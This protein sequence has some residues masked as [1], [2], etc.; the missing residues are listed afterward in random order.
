MDNKDFS[1][2]QPNI[3]MQD[4]LIIG[5]SSLYFMIA[6]LYF[7]KTLEI[8]ALIAEE[9]E[10]NQNLENQLIEC[11]ALMGEDMRQSE[12]DQKEEFKAEDQNTGEIKSHI[13]QIEEILELNKSNKDEKKIS[14]KRQN[15]KEK[16]NTYN[17]LFT[18]YRRELEK[19]IGNVKSETHVYIMCHTV[20]FHVIPVLLMALYVQS[21]EW[22][23]GKEN[24]IENFICKFTASWFIVDTLQTLYIETLDITMF[25]HHL[26][27][28]GSLFYPLIYRKYLIESVYA[29]CMG[30]ITNPF[31]SMRRILQFKKKEDTTFKT[32]NDIIFSLTFLFVRVYVMIKVGPTI[33]KLDHVDL[34]FKAGMCT[35]TGIS[36]IWAWKMVNQ[37]C[38]LFGDFFPSNVVQKSLN[39]LLGLIRKVLGNSMSVIVFCIPYTWLGYDKTL[40]SYFSR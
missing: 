24:S 23:W 20:Y 31:M 28:L 10:K 16:F 32:I 21:Q 11:Q 3:D 36:W 29:L 7:R 30:E 39:Y 34:I 6:F 25:S 12:I 4:L 8:P 13:V 38:K 17:D 5:L 1:Y 37:L 2:S 22:D 18:F 19:S 35:I 33:T 26:A 14:K 27:V 40:A 15:Y 9:I